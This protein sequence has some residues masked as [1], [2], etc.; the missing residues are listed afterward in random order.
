[1]AYKILER[2]E[3]TA[4]MTVRNNLSFLPEKASAP[5]DSGGEMRNVVK[6]V[7]V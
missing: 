4:K 6:S 3:V 1:M 7:N 2:F 5:Q